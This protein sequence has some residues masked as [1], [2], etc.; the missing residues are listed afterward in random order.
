D[1]AGDA[2]AEAG[3]PCE[4]SAGRR[5][6]L[7]ED[8]G[9]A[10][11]HA[12]GGDAAEREP[13]DAAADEPLDHGLAAPVAE[14]HVDADVGATLLE[15]PNREHDLTASCQVPVARGPAEGPG[16]PGDGVLRG[17]EEHER[18]LAAPQDQVLAGGEV[19]LEAAGG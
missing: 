19:I 17:L 11:A 2:A 16:H 14:V 7:T 5:G 3:E 15:G 4:R 9:Q 1:D 6:G 10:E 13:P 8:V 18:M 12:R